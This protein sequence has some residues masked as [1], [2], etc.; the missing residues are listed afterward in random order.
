MGRRGPKPAN[1]RLR[2]LSGKSPFRPGRGEPPLPRR[3]IP[4]CPDFL[5]EAAKAKWQSLVPELDRLGLLTVVDGDTLAAYCQAW[6]EFEAATKLLQSEGRT[7]A[8][9]SGGL[10][11]HPAVSMQ[12]TAWKA[13][14][15][16]GSLLGL[17]PSSRCRLETAPPP[18]AEVTAIDD[19][20]ARSVA[21]HE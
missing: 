15:E 4:E 1:P 21:E 13:L 17:D 9:G 8:G 2:V 3:G 14:R 10:K 5:D 12:R 6:A 18:D 20:L 16:F 11:Q 7:C 19:F